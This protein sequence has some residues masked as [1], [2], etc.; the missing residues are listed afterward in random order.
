MQSK[1]HRGLTLPSALSGPSELL[2]S[3]TCFHSGYCQWRPWPGYWV[4]SGF[5]GER[6]LLGSFL[7]FVVFVEDFG[8]EHCIYTACNL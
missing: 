8:P 4:L 6:A 1:R 7:L 5:C 2:G 3:V